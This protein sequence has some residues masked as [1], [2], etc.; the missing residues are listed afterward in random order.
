[1]RLGPRSDLPVLDFAAGSGRNT[2]ALRDAGL[3]VVSVADSVAESVIPLAGITERFA[4][5]LSTHGLLHGTPAIASDTVAS[6]AQHLEPHGLFYASFG[7]SRDA[8]FG[9]GERIDAW[10]FAPAEGDERG[11]AHVYFDRDRLRALLEPHFAIESLEE[12]SVDDVV[13]NW[14]HRTSPLRGALHWFV[15]ASALR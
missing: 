12:R 4:A 15:I 3:R 5:A 8:R 6:I 7:S 14:A 1:V 10:T 9:E 11:V 2:R 13:G